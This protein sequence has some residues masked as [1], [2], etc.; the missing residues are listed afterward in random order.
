MHDE[1]NRNGLTVA[2][3]RGDVFLTFGDSSFFKPENAVARGIIREAVV[4]SR[5]EV[6]S[7]FLGAADAFGALQL[8]P[9]LASLENFLVN[10]TCPL[11]QL[12]V[13]DA[14]Q[15]TFVSI[16]EPFDTVR[17]PAYFQAV[18]GQPITTSL[19]CT[20]RALS[21]DDCPAAFASK[22]AGIFADFNPDF[23]QNPDQAIRFDQNQDAFIA[24]KCELIASSGSMLTWSMLTLFTIWIFI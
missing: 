23:C 20:Y 10:N 8:V 7:A 12:Q 1:D 13:S 5:N 6:F 11:Y 21:T 17:P 19:S 3:L 22:F 2:N 24:T 4:T 18:K 15:Q 16:R 9:D 14:L